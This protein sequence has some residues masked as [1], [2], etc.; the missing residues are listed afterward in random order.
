MSKL[1]KFSQLEKHLA[2]QFEALEALKRDG[3]FRK[4]CISR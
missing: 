4:I 3:A 1:A 2:E